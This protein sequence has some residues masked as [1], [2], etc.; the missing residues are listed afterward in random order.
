MKRLQIGYLCRNEQI[1]ARQFQEL[2]FQDDECCTWLS[3]SAQ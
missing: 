1:L 3:I 2:L